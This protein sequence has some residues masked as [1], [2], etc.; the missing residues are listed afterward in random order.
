MML[1]SWKM[2]LFLS[3]NSI[4]STSLILTAM[5]SLRLTSQDCIHF[6]SYLITLLQLC[7]ITE[8]AIIIYLL[9]T[10]HEIQNNITVVVV[11]SNSVQTF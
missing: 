5:S 6:K 9:N 2:M 8:S 11:I 4:A 7:I 10:D 3:Y 1:V